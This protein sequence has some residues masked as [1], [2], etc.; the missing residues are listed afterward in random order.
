M[1]STPEVIIDELHRLLG[2][3]NSGHDVAHVMRVYHMAL[4][5]CC[6][7]PS[8]NKYIVSL[9]AL[10]HDCDDRK[11]FGNEAAQKM[12]NTTRILQRAAVP[13]DTA[14][15]VLNI[16]RSISFN[17]RMS[18]RMPV[19]QEGE[20]VADADMCDA[21]GATGIVRCVQ[22][23]TAKKLPFFNPNDLPAEFIGDQYAQLGANSATINH[24]FE[25]L[26]RIKDFCLTAPGRAEAA[27]RHQIMVD[28]LDNYFAE[29]NAPQQ[30]F[31]M[32]DKYRAR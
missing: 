6:D 21:I 10:L 11:I 23:G 14:N 24:F 4:R 25:K 19:S 16:L 30:W 29:N 1:N 18:G 22:F 8:A 5:F 13:V 15:T 28:F 2:G 27:R 7:I 17:K 9:V 12:P 26:L 32:L 20:I 3:D 31:Q